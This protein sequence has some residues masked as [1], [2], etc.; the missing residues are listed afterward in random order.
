MTITS[1]K[2]FEVVGLETAGRY[3]FRVK[4]TNSQ[5]DS[6]WSDIKSQVLGTVPSA[7]TTWSSTTTA[8]VE[9]DIWLYWIHN[10]EDQSTESSAILEIT[11]N[12]TTTTQTIENTSG[13]ENYTGAY[14]IAGGTY[15]AGAKVKWRVRTK[16]VVAQYGPYSTMRVVDI[17]APPTIT[18][19]I[20]QGDDEELAG[21]GTLTHL[22][23]KLTLAT[24]PVSQT[25]V[26]YNVSIISNNDYSSTT[27][28]GRTTHILKGSTVYNK[29]ISTNARGFTTTLKANDFTLESDYSYTIKVSVTMNSGLTAEITRA[30]NVKWEKEDIYLNAQLRYD[31]TNVTMQIRPFCEDEYEN[32]VANVRLGVYRR[33]FDGSFVEIASNIANNNRRAAVID[34]HPSLDY[35]RYRITATSQSTGR[36]FFYDLPAYG[37]GETSI[38]IQ[39]DE[40]WQTFDYDPTILDVAVDGPYR[41]SVVFLP[42]NIDTDESNDLDLELVN[43]IGR[44]HPVSYYGTQVGQTANWKADIPADD[45][46]TIFALRRLAVWPGDVYVREPSGVGYWANV[47]VSFSRTHVQ[48]TIPVSIS[49][50]RV[51]GGA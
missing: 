18:M 47:K 44:R 37:I 49:I 27:V 11:A 39:W 23:L 45:T 10:S 20:K 5:G 8:T 30:I 19:S 24:G 22:P 7:P 14:R 43:Y 35:A 3:Y 42:Y 40:E 15:T 46:E 26:S 4:A 9:R 1:G 13:S 33:E 36:I 41:G 12:G 28:E 31:P 17:F 50:T 2:V 51:E 16:G 32:I 34:P 38:V 21:G 29:Y 6:E 48:V 25:P